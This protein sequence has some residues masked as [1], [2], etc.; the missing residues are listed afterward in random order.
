MY[1]TKT[2]SKIFWYIQE[3]NFILWLKTSLFQFE[4]P[5][6]SGSVPCP[7]LNML[8]VC[9]PQLIFSSVQFSSASI[10]FLCKEDYV[11]PAF[12]FPLQSRFLATLATIIAY[13]TKLFDSTT[14]I[15]CYDEL[16]INMGFNI[17]L[18]SL[19]TVFSELVFSHTVYYFIF[20]WIFT[21][22]PMLR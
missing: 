9:S 2:F 11:A 21:G 5:F 20:Y 1:Q 14:W 10:S 18:Y 8:R 22:D 12:F 13:L 7:T 17:L 6:E 15:W 3:I 4:G 16:M 19:V